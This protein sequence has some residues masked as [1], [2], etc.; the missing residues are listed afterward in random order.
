[1]TRKKF[2]N[3]LLEAICTY[4]ALSEN[5]EFEEDFEGADK[6]KGLK[7]GLFYGI[8]EEGTG[9]TDHYIVVE[10]ADGT[11][12]RIFTQRTLKLE[13]HE[14]IVWDEFKQLEEDGEFDDDDDEDYEIYEDT[15]DPSFDPEDDN[16]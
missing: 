12:W 4:G 10:L 9:E 8:N 5:K 7:A 15:E 13:E 1:V 16:T 3:A 6:F 2:I 14:Q 11:Y